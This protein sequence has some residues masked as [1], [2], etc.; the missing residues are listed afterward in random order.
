[1]IVSMES[2]HTIWSRRHVAGRSGCGRGGMSRAAVAAAAA[3]GCVILLTGHNL[4]TIAGADASQHE[5]RNPLHPVVRSTRCDRWLMSYEPGVSAGRRSIKSAGQPRSG[6]PLG[7]VALIWASFAGFCSQFCSQ[8]CGHRRSEAPRPQD[9]FTVR[10]LPFRGICVYT[11]V[12]GD[13]TLDLCEDCVYA[14]SAKA[15]ACWCGPI[16]TSPGGLTVWLTTRQR[17]RSK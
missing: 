3:H 6:V 16:C 12:E 9:G 4:V 1:M 17:D 13:A 11:S 7:A 10:N 5:A 2:S 15:A 8:F 14:R